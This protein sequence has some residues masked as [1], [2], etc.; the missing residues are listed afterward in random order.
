MDTILTRQN[1]GKNGNSAKN[2]DPPGENILKCFISV[3]KYIDFLLKKRGSKVTQEVP[4][5]FCLAY[6]FTDLGKVANIKHYI[7]DFVGGR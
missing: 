3:S 7:S 6:H 2:S 5:T 1:G 4:S